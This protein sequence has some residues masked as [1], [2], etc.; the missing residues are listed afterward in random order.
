M[1]S[2]QKNSTIVIGNGTSLIEKELGNHI[3]AFDEVIR[4]NAYK[5]DGLEKFTGS[6][7]TIWFNVIP[8]ENKNAPLIHKP[9]R[10]VI[11]HSWQ[12]DM[13]KCKLWQ[14]LSPLFSCPVSKVQRQTILEIQDYAE[15]HE[16]FAYS[17]GM[18][19]VWLMLKSNDS[20]TLT[21]FD[22]WERE[23]HH[24]SDNAVRGNMHKPQKELAVFIKLQAMGRLSFLQ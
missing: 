18:I 16:Y 8:F 17:S 9:Y 14:E 7:T 15:D 23:K 24:Y 11:L 13:E 5:T 12:W 22:W 19:A 2:E 6:K 21:G 1:N 4:F 20:V 10:Q 3:D